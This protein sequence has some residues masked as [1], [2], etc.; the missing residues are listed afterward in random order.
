MSFL[1]GIFLTALV[2]AGGPT[3][4]HLL[5]RR[6]RRTIYWG[7]MNFLREVIKRSRRILHLRDMLLLALRTLVVIL[8]VLAM[9]RPY[10]SA[11]ADAGGS[12][13][14]M[15]AV[16]V[17]DNSLSMDYA[18]LNENL[19]TQGQEKARE[20]ITALPSGSEVSIIPLCSYSRW[21][22]R[23]VYTTRE[24]AIE[25]VNRIEVVDRSAPIA[26][27]L[28]QARKACELA[29]D[30]PTKRVV[31]ISDVQRRSFSLDG[32]EAYLEGISDIQVVKIGPEKRGNTWVSSFK[33]LHGIADTESTAVFRAVVRH[34]G[35]ERKNVTVKLTL[36]LADDQEDELVRTVDL[37]PGHE[38]PVDFDYDKF[39]TL[40]VSPNEPRFI[41]ARLSLSPS[42][43]LDMDDSRTMIVPV[44]A[45]TPV[46]F[47]DQHGSAEEPDENRYG[48]TSRVRKLLSPGAR[49]EFDVLES[50]EAG[51]GKELI[52]KVLKTF[53]E[54]TR[55]NLKDARL[56][57]IAGVETPTPE[58]VALLR[59]YVEQGG[60]IFLGAGAD[61]D[62]VRWTQIA[63]LDGEGIL[64]APLKDMP[65]GDVPQPNQM[66]LQSFGLD[67]SS[68]VG[69]ALHLD[70]SEQ[71]TENILNTPRFFKAVIADVPAA[72]KTIS[73]EA[74]EQIEK[75]RAWIAKYEDNQKR[76]GQQEA[77]GRLSGADKAQRDADR[78][79]AD[80]MMPK[81]LLWRN[82][83]A[84]DA[85]EFTLDE[86]VNLTQ[87][88][89]LGSYDNGHPFVIERQ[90]GKGR[91]VML[92]S[93][94]WP[95]WNTLTL[96]NGV[97]LLDRIMRSLLV[98][99]LP[100]RTFGAEAEILIPVEAAYQVS[101]FT[102]KA[103][104]QKEP[105]SQGV[106][107]LGSQHYGLLLRSIQK[108][109]IYDIK[110]ENDA[111]QGDWSMA[112]AVN[113]PSDESELDSNAKSDIP[114]KI[115]ETN[116][117]WIG[118]AEK[119]SLAG[120]SYIGHDF[121]W[122]LMLITLGCVLLEMVLLTGW[123][124]AG[125]PGKPTRSSR[126]DTD[127][128]ATPEVKQ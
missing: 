55:E 76:W 45:S 112:L 51:R 56:V 93:G 22:T 43:S 68:I 66:S 9:S 121:W 60:N 65:V 118:P 54:V 1:S 111:K 72:R 80:A 123:R 107:A 38:L 109:G 82:P 125:L 94:M 7:P 126:T 3:I 119:I 99:S 13:Q 23:D 90:I 79:T 92:T 103:P 29:S 73:T 105:R 19:L 91:V 87:P 37:V 74:R 12:T 78:K 47:I 17:I 77:A 114:E 16:I 104:G 59:E 39:G 83:L 101:N 44:V 67:A 89:V 48:E 97:L 84:R 57:V 4:I 36:K 98:R 117:T 42:D 106:E 50:P 128:A 31:F 127:K 34:E 95:A 32:A 21:H 81:W 5:N 10:W 63:W 8:F 102:V 30:I 35:P 113:G 85:S 28:A 49:K 115:G 20:F 52:T 46:L 25:A 27:G 120:K 41:P 100:D 122:V 6:R 24:D 69:Q 96:D 11:G 53:D 40:G 70:A 64:P 2:A 26:T 110:R 88:R 86:L 14:P 75:R 124:L 15:H 18:P 61:F 116:V 62:P 71:E 58:T 108:R 33:L